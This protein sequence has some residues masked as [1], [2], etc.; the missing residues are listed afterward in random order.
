MAALTLHDRPIDRER[1][2]SALG[3]AL[4][5]AL[6]GWALLA[7]LGVRPQA[8]VEVPMAVFDLAEKPPVP[9]PPPPMEKPARAP[10]REGRASP[11]NLKSK[12]TPVAAPTPE[13]IL[14]VPPVVIAALTP[15]VG[16]DRSSGNSDRIGPGTG[17]GGTGDGTGSGGWGNGPGGGGGG[18]PAQLVRSGLGGNQCEPGAPCP[19]RTVGIRFT[20]G[21]DGRAHGCEVTV[22]S[23]D[24]TLDAYTCQKIEQRLRY[25][26]ARDRRGRKVPEIVSGEHEWLPHASGPEFEDQDD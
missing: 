15:S 10:D 21:I 6:L 25:E 23:G 20:V 24:R 2:I 17:S 5:H 9:P 22:T 12:A 7:G 8:L 1:A 16:D 26:P 11:P 19:P 14:P 13:V 3:V 4:V 18:R